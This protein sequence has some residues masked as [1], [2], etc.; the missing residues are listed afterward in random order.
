MRLIITDSGLGGLA[1]CGGLESLLLQYELVE[2]LE[3]LYVNAT[4]DDRFGYNNL[5]TQ[6]ERIQLFHHFLTQVQ[7]RFQAQQIA[8]ACNTLSVL[9]EATGFAK[10]SPVPVLGIVT[11]GLDLMGAARASN[12]QAATLIFA[13]E[14]TTEADT[15]PRGLRA[16]AGG[17]VV[18][19]ACPALAHAISNDHSG[20]QARSLLETYI[21]QALSKLPLG[22]KD[23][24]VFLG[25]T[26][27]GYQSGLFQ[28]IIK[29]A[30][31]AVQVLN[32]N[33]SMARQLRE[34]L[35]RGNAADLRIRFISRYR[36]PQAEIAAMEYYL[37]DD[38]PKTLT[39][40]RNQEVI[41]ELF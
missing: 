20:A 21:P 12:P 30:G 7:E 31:Y 37:K 27:Y 41:P 29:S 5:E 23:C 22:I 3:I 6:G 38:A 26:H 15:Y 25:C 19:Q 39:A 36:I 2:P 16:S 13:T 32:P 10:S 14:T 1:V 24:Q 40:L 8:I 34:S 35:V 33:Q 17:T 9:Y 11:A 18:A 4:Q 28:D